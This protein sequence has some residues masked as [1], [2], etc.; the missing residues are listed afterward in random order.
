MNALKFSNMLTKYSPNKYLARCL[1]GLISSSLECP[2]KFFTKRT[3]WKKELGEGE[4]WKKR[5]LQSVLSRL[6]NFGLVEQI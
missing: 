3:A 6:K 4:K 2:W 5:I 1:R